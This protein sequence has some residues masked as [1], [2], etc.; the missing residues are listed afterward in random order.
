MNS[1]EDGGE[2]WIQL[3]VG[4]KMGMAE[5]FNIFSQVSEEEDV[6]LADFA[7]DFDLEILASHAHDV[8]KG[9]RYLH[10]HHRRFQ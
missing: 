6:V 1:I 9:Q 7:S 2:G 10:S 5:I 4:V 3:V 8:H